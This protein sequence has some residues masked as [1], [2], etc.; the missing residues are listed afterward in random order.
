MELKNGKTFA[1]RMQM[2]KKDTDQIFL[3]GEG[4]TY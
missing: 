3:Q 2:N 4:L 1:T